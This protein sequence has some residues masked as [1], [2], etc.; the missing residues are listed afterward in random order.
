[1]RNATLCYLIKEK[2]N[3]INE[4]C[5]AMKKRG[6]GTDRWNGTGGKVKEKETI[7]KA[8]IRE[9]EEEIGVKIIELNKVAE[10]SFCFPHR[11]EWNQ[12]VHVYFAKKWGGKPTESEEMKPQW[13][14]ADKIPYKQCWPDD[15]IWMPKVLKGKSVKASFTFGKGDKILKH[16][17][18]KVSYI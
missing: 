5:L 10:L 12:L 2:D 16:R 14:K 15:I 8:T 17:I 13:F 6:F 9:T 11:P 4:I 1:M 18:K 7:E 3:K